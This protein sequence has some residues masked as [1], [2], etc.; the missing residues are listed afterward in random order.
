MRP[1]RF[2]I[3]HGFGLSLF[4][5]QLAGAFEVA[6]AQQPKYFLCVHTKQ[7]VQKGK[8]CPCGCNK[9]M[10]LA[11]KAKLLSADQPCAS[12]EDDVFTPAYA[13]W[14]FTSSEFT[15]LAANLR[16]LPQGDNTHLLSSVISELD[17]PPP[18]RT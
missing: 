13:R 7:N 12:A 4:I 5:A 1:N 15:L 8:D 17:T 11:A 14:V 3:L 9:R 16:S 6:A 10:K 18:R 2:K